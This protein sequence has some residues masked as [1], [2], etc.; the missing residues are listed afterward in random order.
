MQ[1]KGFKNR[2][3]RGIGEYF[4]LKGEVTGGRERL[5]DEDLNLYPPPNM[6]A[7]WKVSSI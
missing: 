5:Q 4:N 1:I 6:R 2:V 7:V 3:L